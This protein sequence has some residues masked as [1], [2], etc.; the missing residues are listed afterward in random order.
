MFSLALGGGDERPMRRFR[1]KELRR[2]RPILAPLETAPQ[3]QD[4]ENT[5]AP[6]GG[7][8][9]KR[10]GKSPAKGIAG[11]IEIRPRPG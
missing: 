2:K 1:E 9:R 3:P 5:N 10:E 6:M 4:S 8:S 7:A 11:Q